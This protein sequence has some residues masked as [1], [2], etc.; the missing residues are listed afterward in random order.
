MKR[1][2]ILD[3]NENIH[4]SRFLEASAGTGKTFTIEHLVC[5]LIIE[6][7]QIPLNQILVVTFTRA[8]TRDLKVRILKCLE[9]SIQFLKSSSQEGIPDYLSAVTNKE[10]TIKALSEAIFGFDDA[11]IFTIHGFCAR[12]LKENTLEGDI[13]LESSGGEVGLDNEIYE[14]VIQDFFRSGKALEVLGQEK[15]NSLLGE[16]GKYSKLS[17]KVLNEIKQRLDFEIIQNPQTPNEIFSEVARHCRQLLQNYLTTEELTGPDE[18]LERM[19][20]A[21]DNPE[22]RKNLRSKY[23]AAIIDEF[24]DTDPDQW[25]IFERL[26]L[27]DTQIPVYLVGDPKQSIYAFRQADIYT[28]LRAGEALGNEAKASLDTNYRSSPSL[29]QAL[30][31]LFDAANNPKFMPLP[32]ISTDLKYNPVNAP[33]NGRKKDFSDNLGSIHFV[34]YSHDDVLLPYIAKEIIHLNRNESISYKEIAILIKDKN[35]GEKIKAYLKSKNI[36]AV[37]QKAKSIA[38]SP[39]LKDWKEILKAALS[40]RNSSTLKIAMGS[41]IVGWTNHNIQELEDS[42]KYCDLLVKWQELNQALQNSV[43]SFLETFLKMKWKNDNPSNAERM[44]NRTN[45]LEYYQ[46][47]IHIGELLLEHQSETK[48][49]GQRLITFLDELE[50]TDIEQKSS[51]KYKFDPQ[52]DAVNIMTTFS[53]KGLEFDIVFAIGLNG[54]K[55]F[56]KRVHPIYKDNKTILTP[57][58][59]DSADLNQYL[60]E[61]DAE[62]M[63]QL[64]VAMTRPK[65]RLYMPVEFE[66]KKNFKAPTLG[67]ASPNHLFLSRLGNPPREWKELY[68]NITS[69]FETKV[70]ATIRQLGQKGDITFETLLNEVDVPQ[71]CNQGTTDPLVQPPVVTVPGNPFYMLSFTALSKHI[72]IENKSILNVPHDFNS[73]DKNSHTLPS[74]SDTGNL[75]HKLIETIPFSLIERAANSNALVPWVKSRI[76]GGAYKGW[77]LIIADILYETFNLQLTSSHGTFKLREI[78]SQKMFKEIEFLYPYETGCLKGFVDC[79]IQHEDRTYILDWKTNWLGSTR[80]DYS[81]ENLEIAMKENQYDLQAKIY[82]EAWRRYSQHLLDKPFDESFGGVFYIFV[83]GPA[84]YYFNPAEVQSCKV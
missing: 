70:E 67:S 26:F 45:G 14:K 22:F 79:V 42:Q 24:Q 38:E 12:A 20:K 8:A 44:L 51:L 41:P 3:E 77:E 82:S 36:P 29:I 73:Q 35:E 10:N 69:D 72:Q 56:D 59:E 66:K 64:Y 40:P 15:L 16:F 52:L 28:Y 71:V 62:K 11:Q 78:D 1:F 32:R 2:N 58:V 63:R 25:I 81:K 80:Q 65:Y 83:R 39:A 53:S 5:R 61:T 68:Q 54:C 34:S 74:G 60:E 17:S 33:Q 50:E 55:K 75:I 43:G 57:T 18:L 23:K 49:T 31:L 84:C 4:R 47:F 21:T 19:V 7:P 37:H 30:N 6:Q 48:A 76:V 13:S 27:T 46:E 9:K